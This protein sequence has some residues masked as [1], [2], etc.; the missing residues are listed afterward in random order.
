ML[1]D[2]DWTGAETSFRHAIEISPGHAPAHHWFSH[3]LSTQES[4][5]ERP[6]AEIMKARE[7]DPLSVIINQNA[8]RA[9]HQA[10]RY[11]DAIEQFQRT[12]ALDPGFFTTYVMLAQTYAVLERYTEALTALRTAEEIGGRKP[13]ILVEL[14]SVLNRLGERERARRTT[15]R[16]D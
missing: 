9:Y 15:G 1:F 6:C 13:L 3:L 5:L 2:W 11:Q 14:A 8:G 12:L 10:G 16:V 4:T 7:L